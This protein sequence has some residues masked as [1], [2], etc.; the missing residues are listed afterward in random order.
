MSSAYSTFGGPPAQRCL[1]CGMPL[2][3]NVVTCVNCGT[4][5]PVAQ[6][7]ASLEQGQVQWGGSQPQTSF[8]GGQYSET[9]WGQTPVSPPQSNQWGQPTAQSQN[10]TFGA[11]YTPQ[12]SSPPNNFYP[13]PGQNQESNYNNYYAA[14]QQN[15]YYSSP[16][17]THE[18]YG[19]ANLNG[20]TPVG[21]D[22]AP[23]QKR[24]PKVGLIVGI[25]L[26]LILLVGGAFAGYLY[27]K[28]HNQNSNATNATPSVVSTPT[29]TP[30]F[31][32]PFVNNNT[33]WDL[34]SLP[35]KFS[36]K[37]GGGSMVLE[38]D[39]NKLLPE[40]LPGKSLTDFRL[41]VNA[42]LTK[43]D[44]S[45]GYGVM[46]R[47]ASIQGGDLGT[48]YRFELYGDGSYA[49][50]KGSLD[51]TGQSK[52]NTVQTYTVNGA[53][54]KAGNVNHITIIA[55]GPTMTLVVNGQTVY[56]YTDNN[57]KSGSIALFISNL[58]GLTSGAQATFT[59]LA[60]FP[61]PK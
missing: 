17:T 47:E 50:F 61:A 45:N 52:S 59:K 58:P 20:Y 34:S 23:Q 39:D 15:A 29:V 46:I 7:G 43:G 16:T 5:N 13:M 54:A 28:K 40:I 8:G 53:I 24:G 10:N 32:D 21:Y 11:P 4:Y 56:T 19:A 18:G 44:P 48:Y 27:V 9:Q 37:V 22:Q 36:V 41:D 25:V 1:R 2:P 42:I 38:D 3:P 51:A 30:L 14:P 6:S 49:I 31:S 35:G 12:S 55:K 57:Y 26:L 60:V 33:G